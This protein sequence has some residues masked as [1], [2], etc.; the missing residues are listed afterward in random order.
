M[1]GAFVAD[2]KDI[3]GSRGVSGNWSHS[4]PSLAGGDVTALMAV[5]EIAITTSKELNRA[6]R[7]GRRSHARRRRRKSL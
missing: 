6:L 5:S 3:V 1:T 7:N 4:Q 2:K